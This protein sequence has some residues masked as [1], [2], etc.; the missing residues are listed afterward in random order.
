MRIARQA[1]TC[2]RET[3]IRRGTLIT[4]VIVVIMV[5]ALAAAPKHVWSSNIAMKILGPW[6]TVFHKERDGCDEPDYPD[7][8]ARAFRDDKGRVQLIDSHYV[9][10]RMIGPDLN[11]VKHDCRVIMSSR[12]DADPSKYQ[13]MEWIHAVYTQDGRHIYALIHNEYQGHRH[14]GRCPS[15]VYEHCWYNSLT[16]AVSNDSGDTYRHEPGP[17]HLV[18]GIP[19]RYL[20]EEGPIGIF[21]PSNIVKDA[22][23]G[24]YYVMFNGGKPYR[25]Q[26]TGVGIMRTKDLANPKSWRVWDGKGFHRR[27]IDPYTEPTARPEQHVFQPL[28]LELEVTS[29]TFNTHVKRYLVL[30]VAT[31]DQGAGIYYALSDNLTEWTSAKLLK[32]EVFIKDWKAGKPDPI[33]YPSAL[34][35]NSPSRNFETTGRRFYVYVE[36]YN[37]NRYPHDESKVD[38]MRF[39]VEITS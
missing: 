27:F 2:S 15:G 9:S 23:D 5:S 35:P 12:E 19:Y 28:D 3:L 21:T 24:F 1:L 29:L 22:R 11:Q 31:L 37:W 32:K 30:G 26:P 14:A 34:D 6:E 13:D 38:L 7:A 10:R 25:A 4:R 33:E 39:L 20:P 17:A 16:L 8:G 36:R 18:A